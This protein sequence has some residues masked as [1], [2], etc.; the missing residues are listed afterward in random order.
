MK[1]NLLFILIFLLVNSFLYGQSS[2]NNSYLKFGISA[3]LEKSTD[4]YADGFHKYTDIGFSKILFP[5][6]YDS[7]IKFQPEIGYRSRESKDSYSYNYSMWQFGL[8]IFYY[9]KY[10]EINIYIGPKIGFEE[11]ISK[12][13]GEKEKNSDYYHYGIVIGSEYFLSKNFAFGGELQI[14]KYF[15]D[16]LIGIEIDVSQFS[17]VPVIY[18]SFYINN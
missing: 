3:T 7:K 15:I 10:E 12:T 4:I 9:T 11:L 14:N 5:V 13:I 2:S 18:L 6:I 17:F 16:K 1:F 8:G